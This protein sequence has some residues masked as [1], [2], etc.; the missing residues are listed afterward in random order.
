MEPPQPAFRPGATG[1][2]QAPATQGPRTIQTGNAPVAAPA[3]PNPADAAATVRALTPSNPP[4]VTGAT[5][6][7]TAPQP[8]PAAAIPAQTRP[9]TPDEQAMLERARQ[10]EQSQNVKDKKPVKSE[11]SKFDRAAHEQQPPSQ[12]NAKVDK[13]ASKLA[14]KQ[15]EADRKRVEEEQKRQAEAA[16]RQAA[17]D[18][19]AAEGAGKRAAEQAKKQAE[20]A[21]KQA[22]ADKKQSE[23]DKKNEKA[24]A[25]AQAKLKAAQ[26]AYEAEVARSKKQ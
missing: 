18:K 9:L 3:A 13:E 20:N 23:A 19:A 22:E 25:E 5:T 8:A 11:P 24:V 17:I 16:K 7:A 4:V 1:A 15:A 26:A 14:A 10:Q 21:K 6:T 2:A 12:S